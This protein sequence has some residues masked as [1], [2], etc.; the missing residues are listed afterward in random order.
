[1]TRIAIKKKKIILKMYVINRK[2]AKLKLM[3]V[4]CLNY[5]N[6]EQHYN[7]VN[8]HIARILPVNIYNM[9]ID[10]KFLHDFHRFFTANT[11]C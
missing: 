2:D 1:M 5:L 6:Y 9:T 7:V 3:H 4:I 11:I 8:Y 10:F